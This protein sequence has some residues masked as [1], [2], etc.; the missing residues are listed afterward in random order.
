MIY[1]IV[2]LPF[3]HTKERKGVDFIMEKKLEGV[4]CAAEKCHYHTSDDCCTATQI[5]VENRAACTS[6][7]TQCQTFKPCE[8]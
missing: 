2:Q 1:C 3:V 7:E 5:K 4:K 8:G 6:T